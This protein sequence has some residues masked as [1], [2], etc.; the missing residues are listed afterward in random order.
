LLRRRFVTE[1]FCYGDVLIRRRFVTGDVS[2]QETFR[3]GDVLLRRRFVEETFCM[4][5]YISVILHYT[6]PNEACV[7]GSATHCTAPV[8]STTSN[9]SLSGWAFPAPAR[10]DNAAIRP[11]RGS[12]TGNGTGIFG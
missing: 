10:A 5:A 3:Y 12:T 4:C 9:A 11:A 1:T 6:V 8:Q 7:Q 2:L